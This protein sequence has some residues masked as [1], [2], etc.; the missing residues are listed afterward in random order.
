[1][2]E[3]NKSRDSNIELLRVVAML[4][5]VIYHIVCHCVGIQLTDASSIARMENGLFDQPQ[6][7]SELFLIDVILP[8]G[9][10]GN[11]IFLIISGYFMV[12]NDKNINI[13]KISKKLLFQLGFSIV[14]LVI[15]SNLAFQYF[16]N[17][18]YISMENFMSFNT[19]SW[20]IGFYFF[21]ILL[22][23]LFLNNFLLRLEKKQ[24]I[25]F[26]VATFAVTQFSWSA[27]LLN[28]IS[29]D[30][31]LL[32]TGIFLYSLGGFIRKF[33][34]F[35]HIRIY[36]L[37][38]IIIVLNVLMYISYY[39]ITMTNIEIF[40]RDTPDG[41]FH[42]S[43]IGYDKSSLIVIVIGICLFEIF[44]RI[45]M[46]SVK[47]INF[48]GSGTF[49]VYLIHD[50]SFFYSLWGIKDW[51]TE[52]YNIPILYIADLLLWGIV[53][54]LSGILI[55]IVYLNFARLFSKIKPIML[56]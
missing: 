38:L 11:A 27:E 20:Y 43:V 16:G 3:V 17:V 46:P 34:P 25:I 42:Q 24:Y 36:V 30:L 23:A 21:V 55:Y 26:I 8:W 32:L 37:I 31:N 47:I 4:M 10:I 45:K 33:D 9:P 22:A 35:S 15:V 1:M 2:S 49:M 48:L 54:F 56:K 13:I 14:I 6:F 18:S 7:Y 44:K 19:R 28:G 12:Q 5:I 52:L 50:N 39:N 51:I 41:T 53:T 29:G 40:K